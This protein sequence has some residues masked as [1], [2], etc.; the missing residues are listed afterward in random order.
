MTNNLIAVVFTALLLVLA[1]SEPSTLSPLPADAVVLAFGDSLTRGNGAGPEES[2]PAQ[3]ARLSGRTI[4]NAGISGEESAAGLARLPGL[5]AQHQPRLLILCHGGNDFLRKRDVA[6]LESNIRE[7]IALARTAGIEVVML[8]VPRP[9][10]F[11]S[12]AELYR[13]IAESSELLYIEDLIADVLS[14]KELKSDTV[15]PNNRG[16]RRIAET[17]YQELQEAG[18]W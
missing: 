1:C 18:A 4:I 8:G 5:L 15:H 10:L 2:Y 13:N 16:Y 7:M 11:L 9:G 12:P 14:E 6:Q 3:L 17:L